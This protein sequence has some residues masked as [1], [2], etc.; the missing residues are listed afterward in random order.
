MKMILRPLE[1]PF[2]MPN[3]VKMVR[4]STYVF[5]LGMDVD[6]WLSAWDF[7]GPAVGG[8]KGEGVGARVTR[9]V[10][11]GLLVHSK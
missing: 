3:P 8:A 2:A 4:L 10:V 1:V 5:F 6:Y 9:A 7:R 11:D